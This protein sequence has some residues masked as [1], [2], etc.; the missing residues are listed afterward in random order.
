M[1]SSTSA[2]TVLQNPLDFLVGLELLSILDSEGP[3]HLL[4]PAKSLL[5]YE[6]LSNITQGCVLNVLNATDGDKLVHFAGVGPRIPE[7]DVKLGLG[8]ILVC[9][10]PL[11][12]P[13][14]PAIE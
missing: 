2:P 6:H 11:S 14:I 8:V 9:W 7:I 13:V 3:F 10:I 1:G 12:V 4:S 5:T